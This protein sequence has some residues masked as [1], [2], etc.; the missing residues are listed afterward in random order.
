MPKSD[1]LIIELTKYPVI[2]LSIVIGLIIVKYSLDIEFGMITELSTDGLKFSEKSNKATLEALT[3]LESTINDISIR[4]N[5]LEKGSAPSSETAKA[6]A[7]AFFASQAVSDATAKIAELS[8][9]IPGAKEKFNS[10]WIW[11]GNFDQIWSKTTISQLNTGQPIDIA[12]EDMKVGTEY[13]VLGN[14]VIRDG[15]P[16]NNEEYY[17]A[18]KNLGVLPR[19]SVIT[20]LKTPEAVDRKFAVQY[21]AKIE[22][23]IKQGNK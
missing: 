11:I 14:M 4:L 21:W 23:K 1:S 22:Y 19:S 5:I 6:R 7:E 16:P 10:G 13:K 20:L 8:N 9:E 12:P 2:V 18:R 3:E 15:L 17:K